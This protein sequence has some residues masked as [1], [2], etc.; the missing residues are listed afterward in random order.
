MSRVFLAAALALCAC[1]PRAPEG[2]AAFNLAPE[3]RDFRFDSLSRRVLF[4]RGTFPEKSYVGS[5]DL[6]TGRLSVHRSA[7][8]R[9]IG[10]PAGG[11]SPPRALFSAADIVDEYTGEAPK[12]EVI[13]EASPGDAGS[14]RAA[15]LDGGR[16]AVCL[17]ETAWSGGVLVA[18]ASE[19]RGTKLGRWR[20]AGSEIEAFAALPSGIV[21]CGAAA[22]VPRLGLLI[23]D[24][25]SARFDVWDLAAGRIASSIGLPPEP[26]VVGRGGDGRL[27][28]AWLD[29]DA[30]LRRLAALDP[31]TGA[32][33]S[34]YS[35]S[36]TIV[37]AAALPSG[38]LLLVRDERAMG[39]IAGHL[40][41]QSIVKLAAGG[42]VEWAKSWSRLPSRLVGFDAASGRVLAAISD[43]AYNG[44][45]AVPLDE[46]AFGAAVERLE[47]ETS[48]IRRRMGM[49]RNILLSAA[50]VIILLLGLYSVAR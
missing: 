48:P 17:V 16:H 3:D 45:W 19:D 5:I 26:L 21:D 33:T 28:A 40:K 44:L 27:F 22:E 15:R 49:A 24:K 47:G 4:V 36:V 9:V 20:T 30:G 10:L 11:S 46:P 32:L 12:A 2:S 42:R 7:G 6:A 43:P 1:G 13:L 41:P 23:R 37:S 18:A 35:S 50:F 14:D 38:V 31:A 39:G 25:N 29:Q 34:I 8:R